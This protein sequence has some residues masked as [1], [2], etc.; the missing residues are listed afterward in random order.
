MYVC[1]LCN[2][3]TSTNNSMK[4]HYNSNKHLT[5]EN[6]KICKSNMIDTI[7]KFTTEYEY[8]QEIEKLKKELNFLKKEIENKNIQLHININ[9]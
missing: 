7:S 2:Y 4:K 3:I 9:H 1:N 5:L 8:Q 6:K